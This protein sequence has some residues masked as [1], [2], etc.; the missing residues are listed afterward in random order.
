MAAFADLPFDRLGAHRRSRVR[1]VCEPGNLSVGVDH[2][3]KHLLE[4]VQ[5]LVLVPGDPAEEHALGITRRGDDLFDLDT[6]PNPA[7]S[8]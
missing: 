6:A 2:Q 8:P 4:Q 7:V 1:R 3:Q 5:H